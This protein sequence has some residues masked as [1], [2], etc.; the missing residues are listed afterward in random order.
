MAGYDDDMGHD[1]DIDVGDASMGD[2]TGGPARDTDGGADDGNQGD[3]R[4]QGNRDER[5]RE[6]EGQTQGS[7]TESTQQSDNGFDPSASVVG[8]AED[9]S[10][11]FTADKAKDR[12]E[13][14]L[15]AYDRYR[16]DP[17]ERLGSIR[18]RMGS[19]SG[20]RADFS[21]PDTDDVVGAYV[22][23]AAIREVDAQRASVMARASKSGPAQ[24]ERA[25]APGAGYAESE[26]VREQQRQGLIADDISMVGYKDAAARYDESSAR[27]DRAQAGIDSEQATLNTQLERSR[28][29]DAVRRGEESE[30]ATLSSQL[31]RSR[32]IDAVRK[33]EATEQGTLSSQL[34]TSRNLDIARQEAEKARIEK[35]LTTD[36]SRLSELEKSVYA[37]EQEIA[38][39]EALEKQQEELA[40]AQKAAVTEKKINK[41]L[42]ETSQ[43][44]EII[45]IDKLLANPNLTEKERESLLGK[46]ERIVF[47]QSNQAM[48]DKLS[49]LKDKIKDIST[50]KEGFWKGFRKQDNKTKRQVQDLLNKFYDSNKTELD[51]LGRTNS[52]LI[53]AMGI[54]GVDKGLFKVPGGGMIFG[55]IQALANSLGIAYHK[56]DTEKELLE[57]MTT[58]GL[59]EKEHNEKTVEERKVLCARKEGW[60]WDESAQ[61]CKKKSAD[62]FSEDNRFVPQY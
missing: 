47:E 2:R 6:N 53:N 18:E 3:Q 24:A 62:R 27:V 40:N 16:G 8:K 41:A 36:M 45:A 15:I 59:I 12:D 44:K 22:R 29:L 13:D 33:A 11:D 17:S 1:E 54:S 20:N 21:D 34:E 23:S 52:D 14:S 58:W 9:I 39:L 61:V 32:N 55:A 30:Q 43:T 60:E 50:F 31:E 35:A 26:R 4:D 5:G 7:S 25:G 56:T 57:L 49:E 42:V 51:K 48:Y 38:R 10:Y 37:K 19:T 46:K 28:N